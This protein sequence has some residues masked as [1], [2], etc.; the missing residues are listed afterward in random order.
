MISLLPKPSHFAEVQHL[1]TGNVSTR[2]RL[3]RLLLRD[4]FGPSL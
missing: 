2:V 3:S 4:Y 1:R